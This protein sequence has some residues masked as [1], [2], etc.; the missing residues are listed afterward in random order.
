MS[1]IGAKQAALSFEGVSVIYRAGSRR[2]RVLHDVSF[3]VEAG[4]TFGLIGPNGAGKSTLL[5]CAV[6][7]LRPDAGTI[8]LLGRSPRGPRARRK[9][10]FLPDRVGY[11]TFQTGHGYLRLHARL[12]GSRNA[13]GV[14]RVADAFGLTSFWNR[15][16]REYSRG[17]LQRVGLAAAA[18]E[19]PSV[20]VL[21][22][23]T[24]GLDP[25]SLK[26]L[27]QHLRRHRA[28]GGTT[29]LSSHHLDEVGRICDQVAL[30]RDGRI[31][32]KIT[33]RGNESIQRYV[34][35]LAAPIQPEVVQSLAI[36]G[37]AIIEI[38]PDHLTYRIERADSP[39]VVLQH[40]V[41]SGH[42]VRSAHVEAIDLE[43]LFALGDDDE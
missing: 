37:A 18:L 19:D 26:Q 27:R 11:G 43:N 6:G 1:D 34:V 38:E 16:M 9:L 3:S 41:R 33:L 25:A 22:E 12:A 20:L 40:L 35:R 32:S 15:P 8:H 2:K 21:D 10:G 39:E 30:L 14:P 29:L 7:L 28:R 42:P 23:P 13:N 36:P 4:T 17:M 24:S 5:R 31:R